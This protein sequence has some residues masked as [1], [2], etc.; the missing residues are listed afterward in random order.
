MRLG[1]LQHRYFKTG[2]DLPVTIQFAIKYEVNGNTYW[3]NNDGNNYKVYSGYHA[4]S[5]YDFGCGGAKT[6]ILL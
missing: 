4:P 3:D 1:H 5:F 6:T 2:G